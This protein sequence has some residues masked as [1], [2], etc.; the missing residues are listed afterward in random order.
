LKERRASS[1]DVKGTGIR[2]GGNL[3][4]PGSAKPPA[5][6]ST[7]F[8]LGSGASGGYLKRKTTRNVQQTVQQQQT[9]SSTSSRTTVENKQRKTLNFD[10]TFC[11]VL[12]LNKFLN[13]EQ[14]KKEN[15]KI[16]PK[17]CCGSDP[18]PD[19]VRFGYFFIGSESTKIDI[20]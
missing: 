1:S 19:P 14:S 10:K 18:D 5:S 3:I 16:S 15:V 8:G 4:Q 6:F 7:P 2:V 11:V 17:Q 12:Q 20:F 9:M 13:F